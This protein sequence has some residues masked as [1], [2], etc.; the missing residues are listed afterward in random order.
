MPDLNLFPSEY[1]NLC[2]GTQ[3][4]E[5]DRFAELEQKLLTLR[6]QHLAGLKKDGQSIAELQNATL[7]VGN[8]FYLGTTVGRTF[9][10]G[11]EAYGIHGQMDR[12]THL[13]ETVAAMSIALTQARHRHAGTSSSSR[14]YWAGGEV[15]YVGTRTN[16]VEAIAYDTETKAAVASTL[17]V[18]TSYFRG[19]YSANKGYF[20]GILTGWTTGTGKLEALTFAGETIAALGATLPTVHGGNN[21]TQ[22]ATKGYF[23]SG[24]NGN[25]NINSITF[26]TETTAN[27]AAQLTVNRLEG[28]NFASASKG[29]F[30]SGIDMATNLA[31]RS[32]DALTFNTETVAL[33]ATAI[34]QVGDADSDGTSAYRKG[35]WFG[36]VVNSARI[37]DG[38][39]FASETMAPIGSQLTRGGRYP[40]PVG[41]P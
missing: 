25:R 37:L 6:Y 36:G 19:V 9:I 35:Y 4:N 8:A 21:A 29:Y 39:D 40:T 11:G 12:F 13:T 18:A 32:V 2:P 41:K 24:Y 14:G 16:N 15:D 17:S 23:A 26:A 5:V 22:S 30:A 10:A 1:S 33:L 28:G 34:T 31:T 7:E 27:L 3:T 38:L 20:G